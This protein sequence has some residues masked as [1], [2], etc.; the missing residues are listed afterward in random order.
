MTDL[1]ML[2][3]GTGQYR[4]QQN[5]PFRMLGLSLK[6]RTGRKPSIEERRSLL[7]NSFGGGEFF[8]ICI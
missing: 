4:E 6:T 3:D 7:R 2:E 8:D 5:T 1:R